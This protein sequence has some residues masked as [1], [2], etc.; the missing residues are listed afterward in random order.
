VNDITHVINYELPEDPEIYTHRSGRT[1]RAG[2]SG[3]CMSLVT[4]R[5]IGRIR[6][7]ER[8]AKTRFHKMDIPDGA[9]VVRKRLFHFIDKIADATPKNDFGDIYQSSIHERFENMDK[10]EL[11]NRLLWLQLKDTISDYANAPDLNAG[12]DSR[13]LNRGEGQRERNADGSI[14]LFINIGTKDGASAGKL[15][16]FITEM[17]DMDPKLITRLTVTE[18]SSFF[19]V[20]GDAF[21]FVKTT[22]TRHKFN[23]RRIRVEAAESKPFIKKDFNK[24]PKDSYRKSGNFERKD[25]GRENPKFTKARKQPNKF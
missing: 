10:D 16:K 4:N 14:R 20:P 24:R 1:G 19:N 3:I 22:L 8:I 25:F 21:D 23:D 18:L 9:E 6:Q 13:R 5:E 7:V 17:T 15:I 11:I 2:K 12:F